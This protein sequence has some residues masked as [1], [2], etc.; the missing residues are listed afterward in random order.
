[1]NHIVNQALFTQSFR[2]CLDDSPVAKYINIT[3][4]IASQEEKIKSI[5]L[6]LIVIFKST[7]FCISVY[8]ILKRS[9]SSAH[10]LGKGA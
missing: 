6:R 9:S 7:L 3:R 2:N 8:V 10:T 5:T 4:A 1:M